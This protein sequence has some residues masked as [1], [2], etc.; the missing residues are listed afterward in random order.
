MTECSCD[1]L[2]RALPLEDA[3]DV[4]PAVP[5][6]Y[7]FWLA[8]PSA[9]PGLVGARKHPYE[10]WVLVYCGI[11]ENLRTRICRNHR[12][13]NIAASTLR[14][15]LAS[16]RWESE[17]WQ[18]C[19]RPSGKFGLACDREAQLS[20]WM[21]HH[22]RVAW[23]PCDDPKG[24]EQHLILDLS[25]PL[26]TRDNGEHPFAAI[27]G[28]ARRRLREAAR[29]HGPCPSPEECAS[30]AA[31]GRYQHFKGGE[32]E[33]LGTARHSETEEVVVVYRPAGSDDWW[34]R[35]LAMFIE[36]VEVDGR[37]V[38]RFTPI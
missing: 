38:P 23:S 22:L 20:E 8:D 6:C 21:R 18:P 28:P 29:E 15:G 25:P 12:Q 19:L 9:L 17:G 32:Y 31:P 35:P 26:N 37:R 5:G 3:W 36:N 10:D 33:V 34:V 27:L 1:A 4:I 14:F 13:G 24:A 2:T 30:R 16:L 11:S 7:A